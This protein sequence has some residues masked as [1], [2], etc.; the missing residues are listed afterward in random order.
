MSRRMPPFKS[1]EAFVVA[2]RVLS[3]TEAGSMLNLTV[4]AISRRIRALETELG[5]ALFERTHRTLQL[6][7]AGE[8]YLSRLAPAIETI[9]RASDAVRDDTHGQTLRITLP[10][11]L[12]ANWLVRLLPSFQAA[13]PELQ[14]ELQSMNGHTDLDGR[15]DLAIWPGNGDW[16][17]LR[18]ERLFD[19]EAYAVCSPDF[20]A[21]HPGLRAVD[22]L[23]A[24]PL[25][26][27]TGQ[28]D[29]WNAW[30]RAAGIAGP[31]RVQQSFDNFHLLYRAAAS[32]LGVALGVDV[33]ARPYVDEG[34]LVRPFNTSFKLTKGYYVVCRSS[35]WSQRPICIFREWLMMQA[36][37]REGASG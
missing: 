29:L 27:I 11:S 25:L 20:L 31:A 30:L 36:G 33:I 26:G 24:L 19:M 7:D 17:G 23:T 2:A 8:T 13:H 10:A 6:T 18:A 34:E 15:A 28:E 32:G 37:D 3:F 1:I 35:D 4:P 22:D 21:D 5:V 9:R 12:A 14:L 16:P